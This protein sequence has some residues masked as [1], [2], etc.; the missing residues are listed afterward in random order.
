MKSQV[1]IHL[2]LKKLE[3]VKK[4][5]KTRKQLHQFLSLFD[6]VLNSKQIVTG[7]ASGQ[8]IQLTISILRGSDNG[9]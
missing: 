3:Q 2:Q 4:W 5:Y 1:S 7:L 8:E 9:V 6:L